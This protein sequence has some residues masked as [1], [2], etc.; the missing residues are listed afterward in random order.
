MTGLEH[1]DKT[2]FAVTAHDLDTLLI[3]S[4]VDRI[5]RAGVWVTPTLAS[6]IQLAKVGSGKY[7][8]LMARPEALAAPADIREFWSTVTVRLKGN[9]TPAPGIRYNSWTEYQLRLAGALARAGVPM[10]AGTD[11]PNAVLVPGHSLHDE[12]AAL[13]EA[14]LTRYQALVAAT[15]APPKFFHQEAEWGTVA[16][17]K[18]AMLLLVDANPL[19]DLHTLAAPAGVLLGDRWLDR[20]Q[21][22]ALRL[23]VRAKHE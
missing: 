5:S 11:L 3:P 8:S 10:L 15:S 2:V 9:R 14:G 1:L 12:L 18:R 19:D 7:D 21:L 17:G 16:P 22:A 4:I 20:D 23:P 13:L 6:M